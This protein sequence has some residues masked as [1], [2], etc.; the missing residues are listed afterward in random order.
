[1]DITIGAGL[2]YLGLCLVFNTVFSQ[3]LLWWKDSIVLKHRLDFEKQQSQG[4]NVKKE[5][6]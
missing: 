1:M 5:K 4:R 6:K 2:M 3:G